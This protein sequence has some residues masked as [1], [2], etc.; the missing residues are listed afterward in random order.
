MMSLELK[1]AAVAASLMDMF[2]KGWLSICTIDTCAELLGVQTKGC[3]SYRFLHTLHCVNFRN[4]PESVRAHIP[5][6]IKDC[7]KF[8]LIPD[9]DPAPAKDR[10]KPNILARLLQ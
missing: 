8:E 6:A 2:R 4:M 10:S 5:E 3:E 7:L 9:I 1:Q